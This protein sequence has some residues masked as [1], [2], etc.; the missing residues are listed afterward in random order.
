V[1]RVVIDPGVLISAL[2]GRRGAAPDLVDST[3][4]GRPAAEN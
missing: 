4:A 3:R 1:I 2:I